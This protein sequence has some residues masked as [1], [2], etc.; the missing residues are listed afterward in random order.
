MK[1]S[2]D[3][4]EDDLFEIMKE[5]KKNKERQTRILKELELLRETY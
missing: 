3:M 5:S 2:K 4:S 1:N